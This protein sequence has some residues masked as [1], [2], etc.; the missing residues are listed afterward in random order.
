MKLKNKTLS[1]MLMT[2]IQEMEYTLTDKNKRNRAYAPQV[3]WKNKFTLEIIRIRLYEVEKKLEILKF[4]IKYFHIQLYKDKSGQ[5]FL[6][7]DFALYAITQ[8]RY[9][10]LEEA[11]L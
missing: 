2:F 6:K 1:N 10:F 9:D 8:E 11:F 7:T 5:C 3:F 4:F